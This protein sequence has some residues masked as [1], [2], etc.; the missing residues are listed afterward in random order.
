MKE[1]NKGGKRESVRNIGEQD[2]PAEVRKHMK[3]LKAPIFPYD[4]AIEYLVDLLLED[5][6]NNP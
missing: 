5:E 1:D 3:S 6:K 2:V 4:E